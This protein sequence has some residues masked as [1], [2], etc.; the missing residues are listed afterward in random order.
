MSPQTNGAACLG[1]EEVVQQ[2]VIPAGVAGLEPLTM[3]VRC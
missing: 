3:N 1:I 2:A